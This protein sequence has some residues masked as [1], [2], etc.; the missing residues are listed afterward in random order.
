MA[1]YSVATSIL[2]MGQLKK[3]KRARSG[4]QREIEYGGQRVDMS[5]PWAS[6]I[7]YILVICG[8]DGAMEHK[9]PTKNFL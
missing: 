1:I 7:A 6:Y 5:F 2:E 8:L 9:L 4:C 3:L